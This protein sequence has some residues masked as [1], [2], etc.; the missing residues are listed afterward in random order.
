M[1]YFRTIPFGRNTPRIVLTD[2][3]KFG[4]D[5]RMD[6]H[7]LRI[8]EIEVDRR[9]F[10]SEIFFLNSYARWIG[11]GP[12][13]QGYASLKAEISELRRIKN[14]VNAALSMTVVDSLRRQL[15]EASTSD[16]AMNS[17]LQNSLDQKGALNLLGFTANLLL[18]LVDKR[19]EHPTK[20]IVL[21][22]PEEIPIELR[23]LPQFLIEIITDY[24]IHIMKYLLT[25]IN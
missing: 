24:F 8:R 19:H 23:S 21:P 13:M 25:R 18:R 16:M 1:N 3:T 2:E 12:A 17:V 5:G 15:Q 7:L 4:S 22:L 11:L 10:I 20:T 9:H 14:A 6:E